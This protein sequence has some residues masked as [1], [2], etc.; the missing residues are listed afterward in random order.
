VEMQFSQNDGDKSSS[1][2]NMRAMRLLEKIN[3]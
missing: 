3:K 2:V 1:E